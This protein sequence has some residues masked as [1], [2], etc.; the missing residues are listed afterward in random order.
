MKRTLKI[1][2]DEIAALVSCDDCTFPKYA[3]QIMN[4]ANS[5]AQGTRPKIVGQMSELIQE[6]PA[7]TIGDWKAWYNQKHPD[8]IDTAT[9]RVYAMIEQFRQ[10]ITKINRQMVRDWIEDLVITKT[11]VGLRFQEAILKKA[12]AETGTHYRISMPEDEA[13]GIDG[14]IGDLPVSIKPSTYKSKRLTLSEQIGATIIFYEKTK[15]GLTIEFD[16]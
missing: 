13:R 4:L 16:I 7:R 3:T 9:D 15:T 5:N 8:A 2:N 6:C 11:F 12:A 1:T 10:V 14:Y